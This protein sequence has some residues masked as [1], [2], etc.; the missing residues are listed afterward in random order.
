VSENALNPSGLFTPGPTLVSEPVGDTERQAIHSLRGYAYQVEA[1]AAAWLDLD[2]NARLYLE[3]AE[4][5]ATVAANVLNAVQVKDTRAAGSITINSESVRTAVDGYVKLVSLNPNHKVQVHYLTTA[6]IGMERN[7]SDRPAGEAGLRYWRKAATGADVKPIRQIL[8][9]PSFSDE[10]RQFVRDRP[11]DETLRRDLLRNIH[12]QCG[13]PSFS[14]LQREVEDR[15]VVLGTDRYLLPTPDS[16]RLANVLMYHLL[17]RSIE[18]DPSS[19]FVTRADLDRVVYSATAITLPRSTVTA[20]LANQGTSAILGGVGGATAALPPLSSSSR[21][22]FVPSAD[23]PAPRGIIPRPTV[24]DRMLRALAVHGLVFAYGATGVGK[25]ILARESA[26]TFAGDFVL[27]DVRD[28]TA[29][30]TLARLNGIIG[31][32]ALTPSRALLL[33]DLNHFEDSSVLL[34]LGAATS[35][36]RRRDRV[37]LITCYR[38]PSP[39]VLSALGIDTTAVLEVPYFSEEEV[40]AVIR[41]NGGDPETWG[42]MAYLA[43]GSGHPQLVNAFV[44]GMAARGWP[45]SAR[46]DIV[47]AGLTTDDIAAERDAARRQLVAE[48]PE[49]TRKLLYRLSLIGDRFD[50]QL[51][52]HL[53]ALP[54]PLS[55]PGEELDRLIGSW[56]E[57]VSRTH[58]RVSPLVGRVGQEMLTPD[59]QQSVHYAIAMRVLEQRNIFVTDA[60]IVFVHALAGKANVVLFALAASVVKANQDERRSLGEWFFALRAAR[61]DRLIYPDSVPISLL[62]RLA[63]FK[64]VAEGNDG[65]EI[66]ACV[67]ALFSEAD[68]E[69]D[70]EMEAALSV[71]VLGTVLGTMGIANHLPNWIDL[72]LHLMDVLDAHPELKSGFEAASPEDRANSYSMLFAIGIAGLSSVNRLGEIFTAL[73]GIASDKRAVLLEA[74]EKKPDDYHVLV[75]APWLAAHRNG[76]LDWVDAASC[77]GRMA[78][79]ARGW[80]IG[81]LTAECYAARSVMIDEYGEDSAGAL[82]SLD[83]AEAVLGENVILARARAKILWRHQDYAGA[84]AIMRLIADRISPDS[85]IARCFALREAAIS[86]GQT[87]D[88]AQAERWFDEAKAAGAQATATDMPPMVIGLGVDAALAAFQMGERG[89]AIQQLAESLT[90]L[91]TLDP[92]SSLRAAYCHR[93]TR[94]A[95]LWVERELED[96]RPRVDNE[97]EPLPPGACSNPEPLAAIRDTPLGPMDLAW[98]I[99]AHAEIQLGENLGIVASFRNRLKNG[100]VSFFEV[101]LR[102]GWMQQAIRRSD[103]DLFAL[104]L[105]GWLDAGAYLREHGAALRQTFNVLDPARGE[106]PPLTAAQRVSSDMQTYAVDAILAFLMVSALSGRE[107]ITARLKERLSQEYGENFPG[108]SI[109]EFLLDGNTP[110]RNLEQV[111]AALVKRIRSDDHLVPVSIWEIGLRLF[112]RARQSNFRYII[113]PT[114]AQWMRAQ[115]LRIISTERFRLNRPLINVPNIEA[116]LN[117]RI[118]QE[119]FIASLILAATDAVGMSLAPE[120]RQLLRDAAKS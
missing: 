51:A 76:V 77:L 74:F 14:G 108:A 44:A 95:V 92:D 80:G 47:A 102:T 84:V 43:G 45:K 12:W 20:L 5:Y 120:Y 19:R 83:E 40:R 30:E 50:R 86:A 41:A 69:T 24:K 33:E 15:L 90:A 97:P 36:L 93:V 71:L 106:I 110:E 67:A 22:W 34:A 10:V 78:T 64:L 104:R 46:K 32:L 63:Q 21:D 38:S 17:K 111:T 26:T 107:N 75:S 13:Q 118:E 42:R 27:A 82:Q 68:F 49:G 54:P 31:R 28:L 88:W 89:R 6:E 112:E 103:I 91:E 18:T 61:T 70:G 116:V 114:L 25:S 1:A 109:F 72:L 16:A 8:E 101:T 55:E 56:V 98:Y 11:D 94:H 23:I 62:L 117:G 96:H 119:Q 58:Y 99:L 53:G 85:P 81:T 39:H 105:G 7:T 73:D 100:P 115:W 37:G 57:V 2:G 9:G 60:S 87:G 52:L 113:E 48:L 3:V 35:A 66:S 79:I 29:A 65:Q 59:E 4:D